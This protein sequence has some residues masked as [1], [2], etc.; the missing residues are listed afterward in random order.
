M[1]PLPLKVVWRGY[2]ALLGHS[3]FFVF[4]SWMSM[5]FGWPLR[6]ASRPIKVGLA[7]P[8][9]LFWCTEFPL[10]IR[11]LSIPLFN[12][13][14]HSCA[15]VCLPRSM[16]ISLDWLP[17]LYRSFYPDIQCDIQGKSK[18]RLKVACSVLYL[19]SNS[20]LA[21]W[22]ASLDAEG[23]PYRWCTGML[24]NSLECLGT[25][26]VLQWLGILSTKWQS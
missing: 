6:I 8:R 19:C 13:D 20:I 14:S 12:G 15:S 26:A 21:H 24:V 11:D 23:L 18:G 22:M 1:E 17:T 4:T 9:P 25:S 5:P 10:L 3:S 16:G 2:W 7:Q